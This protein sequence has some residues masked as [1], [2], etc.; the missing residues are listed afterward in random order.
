LSPVPVDVFVKKTGAVPHCP[1]GADVKE[2]VGTAARDTVTTGV[3]VV[4]LPLVISTL[5]CPAVV[6]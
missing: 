5:Y 6:T 3:V 1:E 2:A 4:L